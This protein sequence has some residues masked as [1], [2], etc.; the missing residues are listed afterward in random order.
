MSTQTWA[1][2]NAVS[3]FWRTL[4]VETDPMNH[5]IGRCKRIFCLILS[6]H[7]LISKS[8]NRTINIGSLVFI[9]ESTKSVVG[10][11]IDPFH[12]IYEKNP[13]VS[14][15]NP[16]F[17][18]LPIFSSFG[19]IFAKGFWDSKFI[20]VFKNIEFSLTNSMSWLSLRKIWCFLRFVV[21]F[22]WVSSQKLND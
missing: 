9:L 22:G 12:V 20:L 16:C 2:M 7:W 1:I 4:R 19:F 10:L 18:S 14:V 15:F 3:V 8:Q 17:N 21:K 11:K 5:E 6:L 13:K